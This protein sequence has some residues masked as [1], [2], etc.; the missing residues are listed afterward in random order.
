MGFGYMFEGADNDEDED[1]DE[2]EGH[3]AFMGESRDAESPPEDGLRLR[4]NRLRELAAIILIAQSP[5]S[6]NLA[7]HQ[8]GRH[9]E[10]NLLHQ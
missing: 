5:P 4:S 6:Y 10:P 9:A 7:Q 2:D 1:E 3:G 8:D